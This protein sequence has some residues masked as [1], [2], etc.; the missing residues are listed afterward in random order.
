MRAN[1]RRTLLAIGLVVLGFAIYLAKLNHDLGVS[2]NADINRRFATAGAQVQ[3][4]DD[5]NASIKTL[6]ESDLG[7]IGQAAI[8]ELL[9]SSKIISR[10]TRYGTIPASIKEIDPNGPPDQP[11]SKD[12][13]GNPFGIVREGADRFLILSGGPSGTPVLTAEERDALRKQPV[14]RTYQLHGKII[15]KGDVSLAPT[16]PGRARLKQ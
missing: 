1:I 9:M 15:F 16:Q 3:V 4:L 8:S 6:S 10:Y 2:I 7:L 11:S 12:P 5:G 14:G 13:W